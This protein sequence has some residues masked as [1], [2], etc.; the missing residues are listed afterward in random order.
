MGGVLAF[1]LGRV[2]GCECFEWGGWGSGGGI[3]RGVRS[4]VVFRGSR[5]AMRENVTWEGVGGNER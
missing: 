5:K 3:Q 1:G 2:R 4:A